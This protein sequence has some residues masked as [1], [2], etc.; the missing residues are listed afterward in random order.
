MGSVFVDFRQDVEDER[1]H[2]KVQGLVVQE[3][4]GQKT[5]ILTVDLHTHTHSDIII[6]ALCL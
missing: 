1:L 6:M 5:E 2:I 3:E 4:F